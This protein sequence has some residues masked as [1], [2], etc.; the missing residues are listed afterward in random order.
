MLQSRRANTTAANGQQGYFQQEDILLMDEEQAFGVMSERAPNPGIMTERALIG[1][2]VATGYC[3]SPTGSQISRTS[4]TVDIDAASVPPTPLD[5]TQVDLFH[6]VDE[7]LTKEQQQLLVHCM[8]G[9]LERQHAKLRDYLEAKLTNLYEDMT[10]AFSLA[11]LDSSPRQGFARQPSPGTARFGGVMPISPASDSTVNGQP[12]IVRTS[13]TGTGDS[14]RRTSTKFNSRDML[15]IP[16]AGDK[17][18]AAPKNGARAGQSAGKDVDAPIVTASADT[19]ANGAKIPGAPNTLEKPASS[20]SSTVTIKTLEEEDELD[21]DLS[22]HETGL[23]GFVHNTK[24]DIVIGALV[25]FNVI[26]MFAQLEKDGHE[27]G[28]TLK[29]H[30][31]STFWANSSAAFEYIEH[32][33]NAAFVMELTLRL[34]VERCGFFRSGPN[35]LDAFIVV[36][37]CA[38]AYLFKL[39]MGGDGGANLNFARMARLLKLV[40]FMRA[41]R[42]AVLFSE[43]RVLIKTLVSSMMALVWSA[44]LLGFIILGSGILL[45][46]LA[47]GYILDVHKDYDS[48]VWVWLHYGTAFRA[49]YTMFEAT[50]SG[51]WPTYARPM[52]ED[53]SSLYALFWILYVLVVIFAV[54]RVITALFLQKTMEAARGDEEMMMMQKM[55][56]KDKFIKKIHEFLEEA[57][58]DGDGEMD[59][60]ELGHFLK[61]PNFQ[62]SLHGLGLEQ[63]E[64]VGIFSVLDDGDG[65][66]G[67]EE[68]I[69][70]CMRLT[71]G[72]RAIDS[73]LIMHEQNKIAHKVDR[74]QKSIGIVAAAV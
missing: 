26:V 69:A 36:T 18:S 66:V 35:V 32:G 29:L 59:K 67:H 4:K 19:V 74:I 48:R 24:F 16:G 3:G 53:V 27:N 15:G 46:Q 62:K 37:S 50:L 2:P 6:K 34:V 17:G 10:G 22:I 39:L 5:S 28:E 42:V 9:M 63:H 12:A 71:G 73:V 72:A 11:Y 55:K 38:D 54:I 1:P 31:P 14:S 8:E 41:F 49:T 70:G 61:H 52:I 45:A 56:D 43:L 20:T 7:V 40:K 21:P 64:V 57:D 68:F 33:F 44:V 58:E 13:T 51:G 60:H 65:T 25:V 30:D 47:A 23:A